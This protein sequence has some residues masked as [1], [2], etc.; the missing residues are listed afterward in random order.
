MAAVAGNVLASVR[1]G[2]SIMGMI[3]S[4]LGIH[5]LLTIKVEADQRTLH[6][7]NALAE[8]SSSGTGQMDGYFLTIAVIIGWI[9]SV[10]LHEFGHAIVAYWGGDI[11]VKDKGYLTL[12]PLK[13]TDIGYSLALPVVFLIL[14][15]IALP[16]AAVYINHTLLRSRGWNSA[17]SAAG[18]LMT[19]VV[20]IALALPF[21]LGWATD[22]HWF[23]SA[24]ALLASYQVAALCFNLF[25]IPSFD[26]F[27]ILEP[28]LP[29]PIQHN[30]R[31]WGRYG[32][33]VLF[34]V[35]WT[36][37]EAN[38]GFWALVN[39]ISHS[40]GIP[41]DKVTAAY[42]AFSQPSK[43]IF[44]ALLVG[45]LIFRK[46]LGGR[47]NQPTDNANLTM[48]LAAYDRL[49][50]SGQA[51]P[52]IWRHKGD[53]LQFL[54]RYKEAIASYDE[55]LKTQ[56]TDPE[57]WHNRAIC[58]HNLKQ[59]D[60]ALVSYER[61]LK[62]QPDNSEIWTHKARVLQ[63]LNRLKEAVAAYD[64]SIKHRPSELGN[65]RDRGR[66]LVQLQDYAAALSDFERVLKYQPNDAES[67]INCGLAL[68]KLGQSNE[69]QESYQR[70]VRYSR[71]DK[72]IWKKIAAHLEQL[73]CSEEALEILEKAQQLFPQEA[74]LWFYKGRIYFDRQE[75]DLA[76]AA[77]DRC[78]QLKY[79]EAHAH[80]NKACCYALLGKLDLAIQSLTEVLNCGD[81][82][83][84][85]EAENDPDLERLK[86]LDAFQDLLSK[87]K[88]T[89]K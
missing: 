88:S 39:R 2:I 12:N 53:T 6:L 82:S 41:H 80:Y 30:V 52:E 28:W 45:A 48:N 7:D 55:A 31:R 54:K 44:I 83:L 26:G 42:A 70:A 66:L 67:W 20:A 78:I 61:A 74:D 37:P 43:A 13:Y 84:L 8:Y 72:D 77:F 29:K 46:V 56:L 24:L 60:R 10:C 15:G 64:Q 73:S 38:R 65:W 62:H 19:G 89:E 25:P 68:E 57:L 17:V 50:Q 59:Y 71:K 85:A 35:L 27:G 1:S 69:A 22:D 18:P 86:N 76:I 16:G 63:T 79:S 23:W 3:G 33:L 87:A 75:Y 11:T 51:T 34:A 81:R 14:G 36:V 9:A 5:P 32:Y 58:L 47:F 49:I 21:S 40:L 4:I